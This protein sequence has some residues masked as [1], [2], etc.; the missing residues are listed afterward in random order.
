MWWFSGLLHSVDEK[1]RV[2]W[3]TGEA[4]EG[5]NRS[6]VWIQVSTCVA[7]GRS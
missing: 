6:S 3:F 5:Q 2:M 4:T 1:K 7:S